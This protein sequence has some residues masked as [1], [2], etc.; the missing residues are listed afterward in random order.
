MRR[1][2]YIKMPPAEI[3]AALDKTGLTVGQISRIV[4]ARYNGPQDSM[5]QKWL[6]G[7]QDAPT[8][9]PA[10]F[11]LLSMPGAIERARKAAERYIVEEE[12]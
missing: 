12:S 9:L 6:D 2:R 4:G 7:K 1:Y 8:W 3:S 10:F 5:F 11:E